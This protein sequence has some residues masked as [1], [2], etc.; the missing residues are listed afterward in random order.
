MVTMFACVGGVN[1]TVTITISVVKNTFLD[2]FS[3]GD[4]GPGSALAVTGPDSTGA[5]GL[6]LEDF[7][8]DFEIGVVLE[9][10]SVVFKTEE[11]GA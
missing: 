1:V 6:S 7:L 5:G 3:E 10:W 4:T 11:L 9:S 8:L 2:I